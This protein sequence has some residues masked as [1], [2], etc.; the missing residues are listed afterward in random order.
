MAKKVAHRDTAKIKKSQIFALFE[1][2]TSYED[3][4]FPQSF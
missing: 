4:F 2:E 1:N 3:F